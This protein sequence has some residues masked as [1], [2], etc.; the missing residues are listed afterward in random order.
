[1]LAAAKK[2]HAGKNSKKNELN[3]TATISDEA[4]YHNNVDEKKKNRII[5]LG[6]RRMKEQLTLSPSI[7]GSPRALPID[8][9][10][11]PMALFPF[12]N[13]P[14]RSR[15]ANG[16]NSIA[17]GTPSDSTTLS[18]IPPKESLEQM[19][20]KFEEWMKITADNVP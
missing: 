20:R 6:Q 15:V 13:S 8:Y 9:T 14:I 7:Q 1:M 17:P 18:N 10:K 11:S 2:L 5:R 16:M 12:A 19:N 3:S 4:L